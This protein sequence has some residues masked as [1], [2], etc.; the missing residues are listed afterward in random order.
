MG[1]KRTGRRFHCILTTRV[2]V[3]VD[4]IYSFRR[5]HPLPV[6]WVGVLPVEGDRVILLGPKGAH[7]EQA[8]VRLAG[9]DPVECADSLR[10]SRGVSFAAS[11]AESDS[12]P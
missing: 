11:L 12:R 3:I 1:H 8:L 6:V 2:G 9:P 4:E 7:S 10:L 5:V